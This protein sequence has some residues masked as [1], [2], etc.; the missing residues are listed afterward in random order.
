[1]FEC[2]GIRYCI[3]IFVV[4][5]VGW[6]VGYL[7]VILLVG[8][9]I[10]EF[11]WCVLFFIV[12][13]LVL[14]CLV[15]WFWVLELLF[16][17]V[18]QVGCQCFGVVLQSYVEVGGVG[19]LGWMLGDLE[20]CGMFLFWSFIFCFL[21]FGYY[22]INN[23]MLFYLESELGMNFKLMI[24]YMVGIYSVMIFG[25]V[26]VGVC[27]DFFGWC[28]IFVVGVIGSVVFMLLIVFYYLFFNI[29]WI[30]IIFG[31]IYG[32]L[33]GV[34]VIY[35]IESFFICVCGLVVGIVYNLG[36]IGVVVVF[37]GIGLLVIYVL[38]GV[39]F[40]VMGIIYVFIG[41]ILV[42]FIVDWFYDLNCEFC[43]VESVF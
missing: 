8:Q 22:G 34:L 25:K 26:V 31:F 35:M 1:M 21:L 37:V 10:F 27:V 30:F 13:V 6:I 36:C 33:V 20:M 41:L 17:F 38:I 32:V 5:Q 11:G 14:V 16:W 4:M 23:W 15:L 18:V 2:V 29:F 28:L 3:I 9:I 39:G 24:G 43:D 40:L 12:V 19:L 42:L 7:V